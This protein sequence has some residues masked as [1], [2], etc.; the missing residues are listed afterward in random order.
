[1]AKIEDNIN[2]WKE[3]SNSGKFAEAREFYYS[4]LFPN[5]LDKFQSTYGRTVDKVD[6]LF[7]ILGFT[8]EPILLTQRALQ[9]KKHVIFFTNKDEETN[10]EILGT[11][12]KFTVVDYNLVEFGKEDFD[13]IYETL[14][15]QMKLYPSRNYA[16]DITGGKKSMVASAAIFGRDYNFNILYVDFSQYDPN[17]RRPIPGSEK[18]NVVYSPDHNLP[19]LYHQDINDNLVKV[20][21]DNLDV[22]RYTRGKRC[23]SIKDISK[24]GFYSFDTAKEVIKVGDEYI[25]IWEQSNKNKQ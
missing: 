15:E 6:T 22:E 4:D 5:V 9:P 2:K 13:T 10:K 25:A 14:K 23:I 20:M 12:D 3:L 19:E 7:S 21:S 1:M 18:L 8:P 11:I 24:W 17:L 16:I